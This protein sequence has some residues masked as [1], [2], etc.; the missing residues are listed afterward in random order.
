MNKSALGNVSFEVEK[1]VK[2]YAEEMKLEIVDV[3]YLQDGGYW[4]VRIYIEK[5]NYE[6]NISLDDCAELS[7]KVEDVVDSL[8]DEK[9]Y[10]EV[11]SPGLERPLRREKDFTRFSGKRVK[12]L[13][14][15]KIEN[16]RNYTGMLEKYE[17]SKLYL[18]TGED[19]IEIPFDEVK[20][21]NLVF[22][23]GEI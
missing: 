17:N 23:F 19:V 11:S 1:A 2:P 7:N 10:L 13:L 5:E 8:I 9:F 3:E 6:E 15:H 21:S 14:K 20:K 18:N 22:D 4:Y 16:S 12:V